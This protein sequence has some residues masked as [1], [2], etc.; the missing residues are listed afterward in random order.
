MKDIKFSRLN[1][2]MTEKKSRIERIKA[3]EIEVYYGILVASEKSVHV[4]ECELNEKSE[5]ARRETM[6]YM[7][8]R[9]WRTNL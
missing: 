8:R 3:E 5:W 4:I 1:E 9:L 2:T 6:L 7:I